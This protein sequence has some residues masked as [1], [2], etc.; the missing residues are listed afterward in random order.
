MTTCP[1]SSCGTCT[2][3]ATLARAGGCLTKTNSLQGLCYQQVVRGGPQRTGSGATRRTRSLARTEN[4]NRQWAQHAR[5]LWHIKCTMEDSFHGC[6]PMKCARRFFTSAANLV[7]TT[8]GDRG[9]ATRVPTGQNGCPSFFQQALSHW[10][11]R[12]GSSGLF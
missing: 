1:G 4:S 3:L 7:I 2:A 12:N 11:S 9:V 10:L 6:S 8:I 5:V